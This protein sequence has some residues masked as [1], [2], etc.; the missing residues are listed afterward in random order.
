MLGLIALGAMLA[1]QAGGSIDFELREFGI[2]TR[3]FSNGGDLVAALQHGSTYGIAREDVVDRLHVFRLRAG[4][5]EPVAISFRSHH[6]Q[7][8][9]HLATGAPPTNPSLGVV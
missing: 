6:P 3:L 9:L 5:L 2:F 4:S 1:P 8:S 7:I